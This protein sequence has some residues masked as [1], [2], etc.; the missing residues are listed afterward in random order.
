MT[1]R[2]NAGLSGGRSIEKLLPL[3]PAAG[4]LFEF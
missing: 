3:V 2:T 1:N 4:F